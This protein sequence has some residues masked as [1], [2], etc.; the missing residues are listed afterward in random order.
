M[1]A[2]RLSLLAAC[3]TLGIKRDLQMFDILPFATGPK[4]SRT[5]GAEKEFFYT[6]LDDDYGVAIGICQRGPGVSWVASWSVA[7]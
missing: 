2:S 5:L 7:T 6:T 1:Q 4:R 3:K